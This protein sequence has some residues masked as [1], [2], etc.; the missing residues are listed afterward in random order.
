MEAIAFGFLVPVFFIM[1]GV[2]FDLDALT[3]ST[4]NLVKVPILVAGMLVVRGLP[5][6][7]VYVGIL[8]RR[9]RVSLML[10]QSTALPLLVVIAQI[11]VSTDTMSSGNAAALVGAGMVT[12]LVLPLIGFALL[13]PD[14]EGPGG[15]AAEPEPGD[16]LATSPPLE[17]EEFGE[18]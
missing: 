5:A 1:S 10:L 9:E 4:S 7:Y 13:G 18:L 2:T 6:L 3:A 14:A 8:D 17:T 15:E 12:V 11:G 16:S